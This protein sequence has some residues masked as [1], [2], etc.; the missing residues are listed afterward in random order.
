MVQITLFS[1]RKLFLAKKFYRLPVLLYRSQIYLVS[2]PNSSTGKCL[3]CQA[4]LIF[5][6]HPYILSI[7]TS[8]CLK[9]I[10]VM[11]YKLLCSIACKE[12]LSIVRLVWMQRGDEGDRVKLLY[13]SYKVHS[14]ATSIVS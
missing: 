6:T 8:L 2:Q 3:V 4:D 9:A 7:C 5:K 13:V 11:N 12:T 14:G 10:T 1:T